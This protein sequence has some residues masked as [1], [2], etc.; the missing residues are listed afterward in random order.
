MSRLRTLVRA[1]SEPVAGRSLFALVWAT[2][3]GLLIP[4][5]VVLIGL[6]AV[7][8]SA[9]GLSSGDVQLGTHLY[10][11][12]TAAFASQGPLTQLFELV[13]LA[14]L[15]AIVLSVAVWLH[16]LSAD[17]TARAITKSLHKQVLQQSL[18]RAEVEGAAAQSIQ[19]NQLIG[20]HLPELQKGL[21]LW[22]RAIPRSI[23]KLCGCLILAMLV[24]VWIALTA[25]VS[26]VLIWQ[27][28]TRLRRNE[29]SD[30]V[31]WEVPRSR[32][33]MAELVGHAPLLARLNS[34]GLADQAFESELESLYRRVT[35][36][37][38]RLAIIWPLLFLALAAAIAVVILGLG[39][40]LERGLGLP[41]ALIIGLSLGG[42]ALAV[43]RLISLRTQLSK[44]GDASDSIYHYLS[45]RGEIAPSEQRVGLA[46][47]R[48]KVEMRDV[49]IS[50]GNGKPILSNM[51]VQLTPGS[52]VALLGTD[53]VAT[54]ALAELLMGFGIPSDGKITLDGIELRDVH[55]QALAKNVMWID[56]GGPI[57]DGTI[58]ENIRGDEESITSADVVKALEAVEVYDQLFRL[59]E[60]LNTIVAA[61]DSMLGTEVSYAIGIAR[62]ILHKPPIVLASEPPP[63]AEHLTDDPCLAALKRLRDSGSLVVVLP[64]RL[65]TLRNADRVVLL[66]GPRLVGEGKHAELLTDSDLYRHLNYLLFNPY[67][68][69]S[70]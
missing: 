59:P 53:S 50:D 69:S 42:A 15:V 55:P 13:V 46:G 40:N 6:V 64:R 16:R 62:A 25:I 31:Q 48:D 28:F 10:V 11:P 63:P 19:A 2:L 54:Q 27:F 61:G 3:G 20:E 34:Q 58:E 65:Q 66:N 35:E 41:S 70:D 44:S 36:E 12:V 9:G 56:S 23:L 37:D 17:G 52:M 38:N 26:G 8:L 7:L 29:S 24:N 1:R 32:R 21:S 14:M 47:I 60:G 51:S 49:S 45:R 43:A 4:A 22:Y 30:L 33:R 67:R 68:H 18:K 39:V 57:Y 5:L